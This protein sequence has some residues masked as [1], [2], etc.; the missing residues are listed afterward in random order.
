MRPWQI[1]ASGVIVLIGL[2]VLLRGYG[3]WETFIWFVLLALV[4]C[5][6]IPQRLQKKA[7]E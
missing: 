4:L 7:G 2:L 1:R 5:A 6:P 3:P